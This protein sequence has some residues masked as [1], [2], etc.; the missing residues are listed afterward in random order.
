MSDADIAK[1]LGRFDEAEQLYRAAAHAES[2]ALM[3]VPSSRPRTRGILAVSEISLWEAG[4]EWL[5]C[6]K[7][8]YQLLAS[9]GLPDFAMSALLDA[10]LRSRRAQQSQLA[11]REISTDSLTVSLKGMEVRA[12]GLVPMDLVLPKLQQI[13]NYSIRVAE[14]VSGISFRKRGGPGPELQSSVSTLIAPAVP[15]SYSFDVYIE[16]ALQTSLPG[17]AATIDPNAVITSSFDILRTLGSGDI[18]RFRYDVRDTDYQNLFLRMVRNIAPTGKDIS[19]IEV[20]HGY[21]YEPVLLR[22]SV[23]SPID[24]V[25]R[26]TYQQTAK[27]RRLERIGVLRALHLDDGW[28]VLVNQGK[29]QRCRIERDKVLDDVVGPL[30]N[31][32][33]RAPGIWRSGNFH[34]TDIIE[35]EDAEESGDIE[36]Q[37]A[38]QLTAYQH[39]LID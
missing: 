25:L 4:R 5:T 39:K 12:G 21:D 38:G 27:D 3:H 29:E 26:S 18:D 14:M 10:A 32:R 11:N 24:S 34:A 16:S 31:K 9:A 30:V 17:F 22:R 28:I 36:G 7:R 33:V 1:R 8:A 20:L 37:S 6:E 19:E 13:K 2:V 35:L 15:G 23:R